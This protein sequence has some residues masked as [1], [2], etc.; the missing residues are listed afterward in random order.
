PLF[1]ED[2]STPSL[3]HDL[4]GP[5]SAVSMN[6]DFAIDQLPRDQ[7]F[8]VI[9]AALHDCRHASGRLLRMVANL[10]DVAKIERGHLE[11]A[12]APVHLAAVLKTAAD[13]YAA[14][15]LLREVKLRVELEVGLASVDA[16]AEILLRV[17]QNLIE[18]SLRYMRSSGTI[19]IAAR[20]A[21]A[22]VELIIG[23]DGHPI[24]KEDEADVFEKRAGTTSTTDTS[25]TSRI[26]LYFCRHTVEAMGGALTL[27]KT[28]EYAT[29]F[30]I[31]LPTPTPSAIP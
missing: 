18:S 9:R 24:A 30:V 12:M 27:E 28:K 15:A 13:E 19:W 8:D 25:V 10:L 20:Q 5:L 7:Q 17:I 26:S 6:V 3:V 16:D 2:D 22:H 23:N 14:E 29:C 4:K 21:S 11:L 31:R 1:G